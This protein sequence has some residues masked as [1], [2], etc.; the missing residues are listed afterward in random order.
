MRAAANIGRSSAQPRGVRPGAESSGGE[1]RSDRQVGDRCGDRQV[2]G[3]SSARAVNPA[4]ELAATMTSKVPTPVGIGRP[5]A[6]TPP[7]WSVS[8]PSDCRAAS[9]HRGLGRTWF[10][11]CPAHGWTVAKACGTD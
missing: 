8:R 9:D 4:A 3:D 10:Q 5:R 7:S 6:N 11:I 2:D 1:G